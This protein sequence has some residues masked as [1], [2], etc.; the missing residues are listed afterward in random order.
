M[1]I[2]TC[3]RRLSA[4]TK[5]CSCTIIQRNRCSTNVLYELQRA[6]TAFVTIIK[7]EAQLLQRDRARFH[8]K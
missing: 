2:L 7:Q 3:S 1:I 5:P 4:S 6:T 8:W